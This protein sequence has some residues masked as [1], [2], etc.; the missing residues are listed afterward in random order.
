MMINIGTTGA[1][2][3]ILFSTSRIAALTESKML[4][5]TTLS[6]KFHHCTLSDLR[7][8]VFTL[9]NVFACLSM[10]G[11]DQKPKPKPGFLR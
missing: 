9:S 6:I 1:A 10:K 3:K 8:H 11:A 4:Q 2:V 7:S 5:Y